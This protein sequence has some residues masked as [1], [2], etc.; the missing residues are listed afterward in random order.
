MERYFNKVNK[1]G[2]FKRLGVNIKTSYMINRMHD[3]EH[4]LKNYLPGRTEPPMERVL[5]A[6]SRYVPLEFEGEVDSSIPTKF[7]QTVST[8]EKFNT[9]SWAFINPFSI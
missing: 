4:S 9:K 1:P 5:E 6:G 2:L 8:D 7:T 3:F